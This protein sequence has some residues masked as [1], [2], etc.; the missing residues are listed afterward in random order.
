VPIKKN[1]KVIGEI[2]IDS[3]ISNAFDEKDVKF[4][5]EIADMLSSHIC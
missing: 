3:D 2:D 1:G 5:E 4:L